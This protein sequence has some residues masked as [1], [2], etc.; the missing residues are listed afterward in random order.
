MMKRIFAAIVLGVVISVSGFLFAQNTVTNPAEKANAQA[1]I[2]KDQPEN[3]LSAAKS[4]E[5][6]RSF[7]DNASRTS[8]KQTLES[9]G[10]F[11]VFAPTNKAFANCTKAETEKLSD[12]SKLQMTMQNHVVQGRALSYQDLLG[13]NGQKLKTIMGDELPVTVENRVVWVGSAMITGN[14]I[15]AQNGVVHSVDEVL[16]PQYL[17]GSMK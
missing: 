6:L 13:M 16:M 10:P 11:T 9:E 7:A 15:T 2:E 5:D 3:V 1:A 12:K 4:E 17:Y 8:L 14:E